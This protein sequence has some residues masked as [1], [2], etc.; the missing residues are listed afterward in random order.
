MHTDVWLPTVGS[1]VG[2]KN[3]DLST[4]GSGTAVFMKL[5]LIPPAAS[6]SPGA[7]PGPALGPLRFW[8]YETMSSISALWL[9]KPLS[10][11]PTRPGGVES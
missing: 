9:P 11:H 4:K 5:S 8:V 6:P 10:Q 2:K 7:T 1:D 3:R